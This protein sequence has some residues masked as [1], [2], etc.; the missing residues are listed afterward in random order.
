MCVLQ[1]GSP[2]DVWLQ[3]LEEC[4]ADPNCQPIALRNAIATISQQQTETRALVKEQQEEVAGLKQ[5]LAS[6]R[7]S[8]ATLKRQFATLAEQFAGMQQQLQE[9]LLR[10]G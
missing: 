1:A 5:Q 9:L 3:V 6:Q 2:P 7:R 10:Q 8:E 4:A